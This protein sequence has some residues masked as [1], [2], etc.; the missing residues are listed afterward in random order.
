MN[1]AAANFFSS[2]NNNLNGNV[3]ESASNTASKGV[4]G[5]TTSSVTL[6][7]MAEHAGKY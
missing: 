7:G 5:T 1:K 4:S 3:V 6:G 2:G